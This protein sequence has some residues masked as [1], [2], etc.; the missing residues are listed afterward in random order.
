[1][2]KNILL[3]VGITFLFLGLAVQPSVATVQPKQIDVEPNVDDVEE[4]VVQLRVAVNEILHKYGYN[5]MVAYLCNYILGILDDFIFGVVCI[6]LIFIIMPVA[7]LTILLRWIF[8][9]ILNPLLTLSFSL[10][11]TWDTTC[12]DFFNSLSIQPYRTISTLTE[13]NDISNLENDCP[14]LQQ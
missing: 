11:W 14:C 5:P 9:E 13:T 4:L 3:T 6:L 10:A 8:G 12:A 2:N 1:M 7:A